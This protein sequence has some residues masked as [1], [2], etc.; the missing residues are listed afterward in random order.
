LTATVSRRS[1][2]SRSPGRL[3]RTGG[4]HGNDGNITTFWARARARLPGRPWCA[5]FVRW[6]DKQI[7]GPALPISNPYYCP[8]DRDLRPPTACSSPPRSCRRATTTVR[9]HRARRPPTHRPR[10]RRAAGLGYVH[11]DRRQTPRRTA[12][13]RRPTAAASTSRLRPLSAVR[14]LRPYSGCSPTRAGNAVKRNPFH[15]PATNL[16]RRLHVRRQSRCHPGALG[17]GP[18]ATRVD[19]VYGHQTDHAVQLFQHYHHLRVDGRRPG[20]AALARVT[21]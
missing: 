17:A 15:P 18:S 6:T 9:L 10:H 14:P 13:D 11:G 1:A 3:P 8:V 20:R 2:A 4:P 12:S 16:K 19:G 21:H 5:A 7:G